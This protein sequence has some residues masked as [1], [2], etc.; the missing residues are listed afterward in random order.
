M[1]EAVASPGLLEEAEA[2]CRE[3]VVP[4]AVA[5]GGTQVEWFSDGETRVVVISRWADAGSAGRY[6][7]PEPPPRVDGRPL[8]ARRHG[9][10]FTVGPA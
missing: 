4:H 6:A 10:V 2:F 1:W 3:R 9:W 8:L 5:A 7:E